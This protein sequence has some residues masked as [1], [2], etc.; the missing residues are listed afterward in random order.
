MGTPSVFVVAQKDL[1]PQGIDAGARRQP[2]GVRSN[3]CTGFEPGPWLLQSGR[4]RWRH[5][6][7][8]GGFAGDRRSGRSQLTRCSAQLRSPL[9][10][11]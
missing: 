4:V 7:F 11:Q 9:G 3:E 6:T 5:R 1:M 2:L 8:P 10:S